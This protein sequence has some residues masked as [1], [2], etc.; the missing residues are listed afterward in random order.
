MPSA[1]MMPPHFHATS[2]IFTPPPRDAE[3]AYAARDDAATPRA[4]TLMLIFTP[5]LSA[6]PM[7]S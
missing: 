6:E 5:P 4:A 7:P 1:E 2:D 3:P